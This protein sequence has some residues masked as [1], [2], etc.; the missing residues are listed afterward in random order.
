[1]E[2][3][4]KPREKVATHAGQ[5][6]QTLAPLFPVAA[7]RLRLE[8]QSKG[9][10]RGDDR[11]HRRRFEQDRLDAII[12]D[13]RGFCHKIFHAAYFF[14]AKPTNNLGQANGAHSAHGAG[15]RLRK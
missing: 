6:A 10:G 12:Q 4:P 9:R 8:C 3:G 1:M 15:V 13:T 2:E 14:L 11:P 7:D 5:N